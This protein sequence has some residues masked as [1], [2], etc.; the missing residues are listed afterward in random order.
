MIG[1]DG[2]DRAKLA[3]PGDL[4][5][6]VLDNETDVVEAVVRAVIGEV[7]I[8]DADDR[9]VHHPVTEEHRDIAVAADLLEIEGIAPESGFLVD[10][11]GLD[12]DVAQLGLGHGL[13]P[14]LLE[15]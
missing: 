5:V 15:E 4:L 13:S 9:E 1:I 7:R 12:R 8:V 14:L 6:D 3:A 2:R 11:V 10:I